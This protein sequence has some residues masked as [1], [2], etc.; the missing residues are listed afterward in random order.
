[1]SPCFKTKKQ[2]LARWFSRKRDCHQ[3]QQPELKLG[4]MWWKEK[5]KRGKLSSDPHTYV[6]VQAHA[7][8]LQVKAMLLG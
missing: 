1:M 3:V 7:G 6:G 2:G 4:P 8:C 5:T